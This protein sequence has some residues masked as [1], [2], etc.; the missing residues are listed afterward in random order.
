VATD[1]GSAVAP[2]TRTALRRHRDRGAY[3]R[4]TIDAILDEG[5]ICHAAVT[6]DGQCSMIPTVYA[7]RGDEL[8]LHGAAANHVLNAA[9]AGAELT[10]TVT[11]VDGL[12][13]A[14]S[15]MHHSINFRSVVIFGRG[16][17]ISE[18]VA[19]TAALAAVVEHLLPGRT[20]EARSPSVNELRSTRVVALALDEASAKVRTGGPVDDP[21]DL[22][23]PVWAG[24]LPMYQGFGEVLPDAANLPGIGVPPSLAQ[25]ARWG[26]GH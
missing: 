7:R 16:Q 10:V 4:A 25:P 26:P 18:P 19:K 23:A 13:L 15:V 2:S 22:S 9:A 24:V 6:V 5:F 20:A 3:D 14:R 12:V 21:E 17:E 1:P 8:L 11:L